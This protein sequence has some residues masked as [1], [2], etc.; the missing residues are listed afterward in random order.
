MRII[1]KLRVTW[2]SPDSGGLRSGWP[3]AVS[4]KTLT[5]VDCGRPVA[6]ASPLAVAR[7]GRGAFYLVPL[8]FILCILQVMSCASMLL[9]LVSLQ[10][11]ARP[12][13]FTLGI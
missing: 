9:D 6:V 8:L 11:T 1:D 13:N 10:N 5:V 3:T 12:G 7:H 4:A 2:E